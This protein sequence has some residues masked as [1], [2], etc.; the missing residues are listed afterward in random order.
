M[1]PPR[2]RYSSVSTANQILRLAARLLRLAPRPPRPRLPAAAF[3]P[4]RTTIAIPP[5]RSAS[6]RPWTRSPPL[7]SAIRRSRAWTAASS[8][9]RDPGGDVDRDDLP[10]LGQQRLVDGDE[11]ADRGLGGRDGL[12]RCSQALVEPVEVLDQLGLGLL[13]S[14]E[15]DVEADQVDL[16]PVICSGGRYEVVSVT[17]AGRARQAVL[18]QGRSAM[19]A[20]M[21]RRSSRAGRASSARIWSEQLAAAGRRAAAARP[22]RQGRLDHLDDF[23]F[24][25]ATGDV[26][27]RDSVRA[28]DGWRRAGLPRR[29]HHLDA[30]RRPRS[31]FRGQR[32]RHQQRDARRPCA[33]GSMRVVHTSSAGAVGPAEP[34]GTADETQ[35]FKAG[36]LGIAYINSKHE[37]EA[38]AMRVAAHGPPVVVVNPSFVL[39]P[40]DPTGTS[41][42]LVRRLLLRRHPGL[43]R[44]RRSTS[45]TCATSL[46]ATCSPTS[47]ATRASATCSAAATSPS[48]ASSP[49]SAGSAAS[50]RPPVQHPRLVAARRRRGRSSAPACRLRRRRTRS[51]RGCS[52]GPTA[53]TRRARARLRAPAPR[54]DPRGHGRLAARAARLARP[55]SRRSRTR[56][57]ATH[58]P[59]S[60][61]LALRMLG[62]MSA[63]PAAP[64]RVLYRCR[65]PTNLLCPCGAVARRLREAGRRVP[66]RAGGAVPQ[67]RQRPRSSS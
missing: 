57:C 15:A 35:P 36:R 11:V 31:G 23:E 53:T 6:R 4:A 40:D 17:R 27:D 62:P 61:A 29:R 2:R 7:P 50:R 26:T 28:R 34:G 48:S 67:A 3:V 58:G 22:R 60:G 66:H 25:R 59:R 56:R 37:A 63:P 32:R 33:P 43:R 12:L 52:G 42:G 18:S 16:V 13:V 20:A 41:N 51:A 10:A 46:R 47:A 54:G 5:A 9:P 19:L 64:R 55:A 24:E 44:R 21:A 39:G 30:G 65:T 38:V 1:R 14:L 45:S 8:G 49:T